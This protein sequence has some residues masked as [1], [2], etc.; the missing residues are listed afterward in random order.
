M[1][2]ALIEVGVVGDFRPP[3]L[4]RL[5][6]AP[7]YLTLDDVD[8]AMARLAEVLRAES[9]RA[10]STPSARPSPERHDSVRRRGHRPT[11]VRSGTAGLATVMP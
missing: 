3:D 6:F 8:E 10:G 7:L 9:W 11:A 5:G 1:V 2:Q 4:I